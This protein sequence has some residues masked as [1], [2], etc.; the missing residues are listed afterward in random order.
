MANS[1]LARLQAAKSAL[2]D[3]LIL[4]TQTIAN[5][6]QANV[7]SLVT[8]INNTANTNKYVLRPDYS[9][10]GESYNWNAYK[11]SLLKNIDD[12]NGLIQRESMPFIVRSRAR[13]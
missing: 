4:V 13:P 10:D 8:A 1:N 9:L 7:D 11:D 12:I 6:T 5:P 2:I 3:L